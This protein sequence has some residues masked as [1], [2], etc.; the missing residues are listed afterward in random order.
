[1]IVCVCVKVKMMVKNRTD[2]WI[3]PQLMDSHQQRKHKRIMAISG[4]IK[5]R[6]RV[7]C[8]QF[9]AEM[10]YHGLRKTVAEEYIEVLKDLKMVKQ[11]K[12]DIVW[13]GEN[14]TN[15]RRTKRRRQEGE[16]A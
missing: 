10:Q 6:S 16:K 14:E 12:E 4:V 9:L 8:K 1:M 7:N 2:G 3:D 11:D 13:N 15:E 5:K